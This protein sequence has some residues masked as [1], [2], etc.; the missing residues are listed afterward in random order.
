MAESL[1]MTG[2]WPGGYWNG[3]DASGKLILIPNYP[4]SLDA[5]HDAVM[6]LPIEQHDNFE[7]NLAV[8][9]HGKF[10]R[11]QVRYQRF[12]TTNATAKERCLAYLKTKGILP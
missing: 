12:E 6:A 4:E 2:V 8:I 1:G 5:I 3:R 9:V 10:I 11:H 7:V